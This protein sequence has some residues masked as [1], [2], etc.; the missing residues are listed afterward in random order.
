MAEMRRRAVAVQPEPVI[1]VDERGVLDLF[2]RRGHP[3]AGGEALLGRVLQV[4]H[5]EEWR[6]FAECMIDELI[7]VNLVRIVG[8]VRRHVAVLPRPAGMIEGAHNWYEFAEEIP[9]GL[10]G[11]V[12]EHHAGMVPVVEHELAHLF[13]NVVLLP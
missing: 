3:P 5:L 1:F 8:R 10:V 9:D 2:R 13:G 11:S 4:G 12:P 7:R 6:F